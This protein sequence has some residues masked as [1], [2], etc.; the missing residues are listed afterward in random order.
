MPNT[1]NGSST[2]SPPLVTEEC[3]KKSINRW[4][5]FRPSPAQRGRLSTQRGTYSGQNYNFI[6]AGDFGN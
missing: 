6:I 2:K 3:E 1:P 4:S 5:F